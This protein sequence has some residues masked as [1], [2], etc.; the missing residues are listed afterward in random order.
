MHDFNGTPL[1][2]GDKVMIP[3]EVKALSEG[4]EEFCNVTVETELGRRPD[5]ARETFSSINTNQVILLRRCS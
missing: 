4:N 2:V 1:K 5:G 3:C